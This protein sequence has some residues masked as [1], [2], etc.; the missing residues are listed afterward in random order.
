MLSRF[1]M[2]FETLY[3][4]EIMIVIFADA[5]TAVA[6]WNACLCDC[7]KGDSEM[8][9]QSPVLVREKYYWRN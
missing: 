8:F 6:E 9:V 7:C 4:S 2:V 3:K 1:V 5:A